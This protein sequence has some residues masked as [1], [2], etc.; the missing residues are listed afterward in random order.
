MITA[1]ELIEVLKKLPPDT[2]VT[3]DSGY[4]GLYKKNMRL[5]E[6]ISVIK[7]KKIFILND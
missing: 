3:Y 1:G 6:D 4:G 2:E 5:S 7:R